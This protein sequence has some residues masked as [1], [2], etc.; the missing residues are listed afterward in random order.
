MAPREVALAALLLAVFG[1]AMHFLARSG[2]LT[3][4]GGCFTGRA[5]WQ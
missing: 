5:P 1:V 3:R 2:C 4:G